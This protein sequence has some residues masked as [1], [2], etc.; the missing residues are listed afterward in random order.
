MRKTL[1][2]RFI[3]YS[4]PTGV[5]GCHLWMGYK[6]PNGYGQIWHSGKMLQ[7][8][9]VAYELYKG[10]IPD[11]LEIDHLCRNRMCVNPDHLEA[12]THA[13]NVRRAAAVI[14]HCPQGH[15]YE[16]DNLY[17]CPRGKREC[18]TCVRDRGRAYRARKRLEANDARQ[19]GN[20]F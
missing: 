19:T 4:L 13:E 3:R 14:T 16:G 17:V 6:Q 11:G 12:V 8:H 5:G 18:R 9:R 7:A 20:S 1:R 10:A 15:L 2:E